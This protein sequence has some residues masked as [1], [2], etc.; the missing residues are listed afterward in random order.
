MGSHIKAIQEQSQG[1]VLAIIWF[2][3]YS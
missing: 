3:N 1:Y 2:Y